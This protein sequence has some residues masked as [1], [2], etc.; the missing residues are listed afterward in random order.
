MHIPLIFTHYPPNLRTTG[1]PGIK[2]QRG[3]DIRRNPLSKNP[4]LSLQNI[5]NSVNYRKCHHTAQEPP[6]KSLP[7][8]PLVSTINCFNDR[9]G[10]RKRH[11]D[12]TEKSLARYINI[13]EIKKR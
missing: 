3:R 8:P 10:H 7:K 12:H 9:V 11:N 13:H 4:L 5:S 2:I 6:I 1:A